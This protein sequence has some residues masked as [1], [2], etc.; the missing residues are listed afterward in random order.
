MKSLQRTRISLAVASALG[1]IGVAHAQAP[2]AVTVNDVLTGNST[3]SIW[4]PQG[5]ACLTAGDN[6]STYPK[7]CTATGFTYYTG[8]NSTLVGGA[9]GTLP[10]ASGSGALRLTN[11]DTTSGGSNGDNENGAVI[12][13]GPRASFDPTNPH[14]GAFPSN[15]GIQLTWTTVTYGGDNLNNTGADGISFFL[16]DAGDPVNNKYTAA[17]VGGLGGSL[18]YSCS[19]GNAQAD[20]V[21]LGYLG[22][23]IDEYG[24]FSNSGD[25]TNTSPP[26]PAPAYKP[27][28]ISVRA[29]GST[30]WDWLNATYPTWYPTSIQTG[31]NAVS[32]VQKTC[33]AGYAIDFSKGISNG[34]QTTTKLLNYKFLQYKD[35][36]ATNPI[37]NQEGVAK[38]LRGNA[39][40]ISYS[41]K[42]TT[43]GYLTFSYSYNGGT[44]QNVISNAS[45]LKITDQNGPLPNYFGFGFSSGTGG[46]NNVHEITCFKAAPVNESN[47]SAGSNVQ[48]SAKVISGSQLYLAF[49]HPTNWWGQLTAQAL[50]PDPTNHALTVASSSTWDANCVLTGGTCSMMAGSP[51][52]GVQASSNRTILSWSGSAGI[53]FQW[54][55]LSAA[56]KTA[57]TGGDVD[58]NGV[59]VSTADR[60]NYLR[61]DRSKEVINGGNFRNRSGVLGDIVDSSPTWVGNPG[62]PY[63]VAWQDKLSTATAPEGS[64]Y[65]AFATSNKTRQNVVYVG[66]NDGLLHGFRAGSFDTSGNFVSANNDGLE[67]LA[68]MPSQV[69]NSI[70]PAAAADNGIDYSDSQYSHNFFVDATPGTGDLY[71]KGA[72][73]TWLVGG[74][75]PGGQ[76]PDAVNDATKT[77]S[78][79]IYGLDITDPTQFSE[80]NAANLVITDMQAADITAAGCFNVASN[81]G[82]NLGMTYGTPQI[83]RLHDGN[84]AVIWGNGLGSTNG[85]AGIFIMHVNSSTGA[86]TLRY[87]DTGSGS[88]TGTRNGIVEV[89]PVDLD[90]DHITDYVYA[91]D[92]YGNVWRF[93]LTSSTP[94]NWKAGTSPIFTTTSGQPITTK[95]VVGAVPTPSTG[96]MKVIVSFGT[97]QKLPQNQASS[98]VYASGGQS[99]Y[100][101]WDWNMAAWNAL[102]S[103]AKFDSLASPQTVTPAK[104]QTQTVTSTV[105][106]TGN[107]T[108]YRSVSSNVVCWAGSSTCTGG[109]SA[110]QQFGWT[111]ALPTSSEQVNYNPLGTS[112]LF[113]V[114]TTIPATQ[115]VINCS[116]TPAAGYTMALQLGTGGASTSSVFADA[117][118][119]FENQNISGIGVS[120]TGTPTVMVSGADNFLVQQTLGGTG[121]ADQINITGGIGQRLNW[122]KIR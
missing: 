102:G 90:G 1:L 96:A 27:G 68:Y 113:I 103:D 45:P 67:V 122:T 51:S 65:G 6:S 106:G 108:G 93:D 76:Y 29:G 118:G 49:F 24:N 38:P 17:T 23:G 115:N 109:T 79:S 48:Q 60:L 54:S 87:L 61:G 18:G 99:L 105:A 85:K 110:N 98:E 16:F 107:V 83:R 41:L 117:S 94:S 114:N 77:G 11:G 53:P 2:T 78:G 92:F 59:S 21:M 100:G 26:S 63:A 13:G 57:L 43:D 22:V 7:G 50:I 91:G 39:M 42:I 47:S 44:A 33:K 75:G 62:S 9:T 10:D 15:Q 116:S 5:G 120:G 111:L 25:N 56:Q 31:G 119:S 12:W 112:G 35:V 95:L 104:L 8:K 101:V 14:V 81:C 74:L 71:Y 89:T 58:S 82:N 32:A 30:R 20:G 37:A 88:T 36:P 34:V 72:W 97:G 121:R 3:A 52:I 55:N 19:N 70:H 86:R 28:R 4:F 64:S 73:H 46:G 69:L 80:S 40:P 84:W 66:S